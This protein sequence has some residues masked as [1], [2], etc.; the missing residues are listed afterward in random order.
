MHLTL[1][2]AIRQARVVLR[3]VIPMTGPQKPASAKRLTERQMAE[4]LCRPSSRDAPVP[5]FVYGL[6]DVQLIMWATCRLFGLTKVELQS[7]VR[8]HRIVKRRQAAFIV[9]RE[10]TAMSY[11]QLG[12]QFGAAGRPFDHTTALHA[13]KNAGRGTRY[14]SAET[15]AGL[16]AEIRSFVLEI[17]PSLDPSRA[18]EG[19]R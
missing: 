16:V 18:W 11:P 19:Y 14:C 5:D 12:R 7:T 15:F 6:P 13:I 1:A 9:A 2:Q 4:S 10:L 3:D 8:E 17:R